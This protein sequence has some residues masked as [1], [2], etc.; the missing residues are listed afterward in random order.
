MTPSSAPNL[1]A[2]YSE[3]AARLRSKVR[4]LLFT[5]GN[6]GDTPRGREALA[7]AA[8]YERIATSLA[9][10]QAETLAARDG[11]LTEYRKSAA[12]RGAAL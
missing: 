4:S 2:S 8:K 11:L 5:A 1:S 10:K 6:Y 3:M 7:D 12:D 9:E